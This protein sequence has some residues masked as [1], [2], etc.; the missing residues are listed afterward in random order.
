MVEIQNCYYRLYYVGTDED[1]NTAI[2]A[3]ESAGEKF[4]DWKRIRLEV[5][6]INSEN[7]E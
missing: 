1:G 6:E 3:A 7:P 2:G 5:N 4:Q